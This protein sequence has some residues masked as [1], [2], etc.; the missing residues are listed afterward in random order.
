MG[1]QSSGFAPDSQC[2][3]LVGQVRSLVRGFFR[4][5]Q[6]AQ[7]P[8]FGRVTS[9]NALILSCISMTKPEGLAREI[10]DPK[11]AEAGADFHA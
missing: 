4:V 2:V 5:I 10:I 11:L 6:A 9:E 7:Y 3:P 1:Y 8:P